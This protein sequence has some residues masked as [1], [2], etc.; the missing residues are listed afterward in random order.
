MFGRKKTKSAA[1]TTSAA[2]SESEALVT[3]RVLFKH[4]E[5]TACQS[6][7]TADTH[8]HGARYVTQNGLIVMGKITGNELLTVADDSFIVVAA[9]AEIEAGN[10]EARDLLIEGTLKDLT[11]FVTGR[12]EISASAVVS[13][14]L[15][16]GPNAELYISPAADVDHMV[17]EVAHSSGAQRASTQVPP[18]AKAQPTSESSLVTLTQQLATELKSGAK[19]D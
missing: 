3:R 6:V 19:V 2:P 4:D 18:L 12:I 15:V 10:I 13:G 8:I 14:T 11:I 17:M 16:K 9:G 7:I 5:L 1:A